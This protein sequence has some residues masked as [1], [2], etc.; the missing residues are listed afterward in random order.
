MV[1]LSGQIELSR[2][3]NRLVYN[4]GSWPPERC[5]RALLQRGGAAG[6]GAATEG[7]VDEGSRG[8]DPNPRP[9]PDTPA[10]AEA[11][12]NATDEVIV[13]ADDRTRVNAT[14]TYP[15]RAIGSLVGDTAKNSIECTAAL[16]SPSFLITAAH[17]V[18]VPNGG[19]LSNLRFDAGRDDA[20][21]P[22]GTAKGVRASVPDAYRRLADADTS[23]SDYGSRR[24]YD[25]AVVKLDTTIGDR[26][27]YFG[28]FRDFDN[29]NFVMNTA[30]YPF[31]KGN[32][33]WF[34]TCD[35]QRISPS[36]GSVFPYFCD[37]Q[38]GNSG[39]PIWVN[40]D[41]KRYYIGIHTGSD[42]LETNFGTRYSSEVHAF[43]VNAMATF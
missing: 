22:Y 37:T 24:P 28:R 32:Q 42:S 6:G 33:M 12:R 13:G 14:T 8:T 29:S 27:G 2:P 38:P 25:W 15:W 26:L 11:A 35:H 7:V 10:A 19:Y 3:R 39:G 30:G 43:V 41:G 5:R 31:D 20:Q 18:Y 4:R 17:C 40:Q 36:V 9:T 34:S 16:I 23:D 1:Q 21:L